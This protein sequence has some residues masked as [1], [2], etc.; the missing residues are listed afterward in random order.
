MVAKGA[1]RWDS[2]RGGGFDK[3]SVKKKCRRMIFDFR[4]FSS[5]AANVFGMNLGSEVIV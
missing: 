1:G 2:G 4:Q 3:C 5:Q